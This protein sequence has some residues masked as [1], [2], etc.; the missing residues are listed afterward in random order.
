MKNSSLDILSMNV[1]NGLKQTEEDID[2]LREIIKQYDG[3][4]DD[5]QK[6]AI[7]AELSVLTA[8]YDVLSMRQVNLT[9]AYW[10]NNLKPK[11]DA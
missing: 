4:L 9:G 7:M 5:I 3:E 10:Q 1:I 8:R 11:A 2:N 6:R